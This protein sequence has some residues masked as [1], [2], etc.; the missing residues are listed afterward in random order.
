MKRRLPGLPSLLRELPPLVPR[1]DDTKRTDL[2]Y[3]LQS[4]KRWREMVIARAGRRCEAVEHGVRCSKAGPEATLYA[5]HIIELEDGGARLD[6]RNGR[7]LCARHHT[8]KTNKARMA[9]LKS[10]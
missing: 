2:R 8:I 7:C 4:H 9:R 5:D 6:P 3:G 10:S 1:L